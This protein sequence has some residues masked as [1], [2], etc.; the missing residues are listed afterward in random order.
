MDRSFTS[1]YAKEIY[2]ALAT[3]TKQATKPFLD[4][5]KGIVTS[6]DPSKLVEEVANLIVDNLLHQSSEDNSVNAILKD[7]MEKVEKGETLIYDKDI[8]GKIPWSDPTIMNKLFS[9]LSTT[10]TNLAVKM[11]FAGTLSVICPTDGVEKIYGD[12][13]LNS[14]T[15]IFD[16]NGSTRTEL[17]ED[18]L[19]AYQESVAAGNE[20]D[21]DGHNM[22]VLDLS[23]DS[24]EATGLDNEQSQKYKLSKISELKT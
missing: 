19:R 6:N 10:L 15:K 18:S 11:K 20:V 2:T 9:S 12:R 14:F 17:S 23:R 16:E 1:E 8:K 13:M 4:G 21:S 7:L 3:L 24:A 5:I 22:L